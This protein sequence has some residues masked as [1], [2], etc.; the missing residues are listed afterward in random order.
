MQKDT[1]HIETLIREHLAGH[2]CWTAMASEYPEGFGLLR[3]WLLTPGKRV[4]PLLFAAAC[5]DFGVEPFPAFSPAALALELAHS[6]ILVH[7]DLIDRSSIRREAPTLTHA[8]GRSFEDNP[9][10]GF[11]GG[12][13]ALVGGDLLFS[14]AVESLLRTEVGDGVKQRMLHC[15][16]TAAQETA[17][18]ALLEMKAAQASEGAL[19]TADIEAVYALKTGS[20]TFTLPLK[21]AA[22]CSDASMPEPDEIGR[23]AGIAFQL[24]ND[25]KSLERWRQTGTE[26]D[27]VRDRRRTWP[28]VYAGGRDALCAQETLDALRAAVGRH[29]RRAL[30]L[31]QGLPLSANLINRILEV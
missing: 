8:A 29:A 23:E 18:G 10:D 5:R 25:L 15:F 28:F 3:D 21:L 30:R 1:A 24:V 12:D 19:C 31:A 6:F 26:P 7:D 13:F 4:R 16:M 14:L 27:D 17:R 9:A 11:Q 22:L 2:S 20:Y